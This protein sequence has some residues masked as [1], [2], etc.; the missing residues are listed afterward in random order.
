M[1]EERWT[2]DS[3]KHLAIAG[4]FE[5]SDQDL[6]W[7]DRL[8]V[9]PKDAI[10]GKVLCVC[11]GAGVAREVV[12]RLGGDTRPADAALELLGQWIDDPSDERFDQIYALIFKGELP[13][14]DAHDVVSW[15]LRVAT[16]SV[17]N[18][19]AGWALSST[20]DHAMKAGLTPEQ[21]RS[22]AE[23]ELASRSRPTNQT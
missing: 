7:C 9:A 16:S 18:F 11:V 10:V 19:E 20:C 14:F 2:W 4:V 12:A 23:R 6:G 8:E 1:P 13:R 17:G 22:V 5:A 21:L 15:A 3:S